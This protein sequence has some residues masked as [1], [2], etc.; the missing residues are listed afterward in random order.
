MSRRRPPAPERFTHRVNVLLT[1]AQGTHLQAQAHTEGR[2]LPNLLRRIL[3]L[4]LAEH[5]TR[6]P[7]PLKRP[8]PRV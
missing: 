6:V 1:R 8:S 5:G 4:A 3:A 7:P 2:T